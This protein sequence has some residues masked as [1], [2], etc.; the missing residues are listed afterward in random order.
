MGD[1]TPVGPV[2]GYITLVFSKN[3]TMLL[4]YTVNDA[5]IGA[6]VLANDG[7]GWRS[8]GD[9]GSLVGGILSRWGVSLDA[10]VRWT[11]PRMRLCSPLIS[12]S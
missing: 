4:G 7:T 8:L 2:Q 9:P 1:Y 12:I 5:A 3:D 6:V 10:H 11:I